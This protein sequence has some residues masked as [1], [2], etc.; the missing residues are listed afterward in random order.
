MLWLKV[1]TCTSRSTA[2][3]LARY[4][5]HGYLPRVA[6]CNTNDELDTLA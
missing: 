5:R 4:G 2:P 1:K 6:L 3:L